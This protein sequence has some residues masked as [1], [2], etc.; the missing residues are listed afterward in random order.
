MLLKLKAWTLNGLKM[1]SNPFNYQSE[2]CKSAG[3]H[4]EANIYSEIAEYYEANG[5]EKTAFAIN[6]TIGKSTHESESW[7][8]L[9]LRDALRWIK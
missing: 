8:R 1:P 5:P 2:V 4:L 9:F 6:S 3:L 7:M